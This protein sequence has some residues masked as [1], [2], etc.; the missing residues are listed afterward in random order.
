MGTTVR[1]CSRGEVSASLYNNGVNTTA[2]THA[3]GDTLY[4]A[5]THTGD[6]LSDAVTRQSLGTLY[7]NGEN[8]TADTHANGN[9]L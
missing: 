3:S 5:Y 6:K 8:M 1:R 9:A 7:N 4:L 2:N